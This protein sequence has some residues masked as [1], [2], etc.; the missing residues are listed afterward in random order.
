MA[1]VIVLCEKY[2]QDLELLYPVYRLREAGHKVTIVGVEKVQYSGKHG[3]P[4][5]ADTSVDKISSKDFDAIVIPGGWAPDYLRRNKKILRLVEEMNQQKKPIAAICHAG[6]VLISAN[7][8]KG[9]TAT[10]FIAIRDDIV[11][12]GAN[13]L[14]KEV[15]V[16][17]N[18]ITSRTPDDLPAFMIELLKKLK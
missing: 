12:A 17:G 1:K 15:V 11:N 5:Q 14:D 3:Y 6:W 13:Y 8:L 2:F 16:D 18:L 9:R 10:G 7:I 4:I